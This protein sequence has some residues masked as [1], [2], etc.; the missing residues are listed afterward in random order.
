M[1][2]TARWSAFGLM[3]LALGGCSSD[4]TDP[5]NN[6]PA[7]IAVVS[8]QVTQSNDVQEVVSVHL[9]NSGGPGAFKLEFWGI[10]HSPN[11]PDSFYGETEA[12]EVAAGYDETVSYTVSG[13][14]VLVGWLYVDMRDQGSAAYRQSPRVNIDRSAIQ[15][16]ASPTPAQRS[17]VTL[18]RAAGR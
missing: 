9:T 2:R 12:V 3:A 5:G 8:A 6:G 10:P 14:N 16:L 7:N 1:R 4:T 13:S 15:G 18:R 17:P 11:G